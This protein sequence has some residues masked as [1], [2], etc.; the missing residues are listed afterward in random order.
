MGFELGESERTLLDEG[1]GRGEMGEILND[2]DGGDGDNEAGPP[3][4]AKYFSVCPGHQNACVRHPPSTPPQT[5]G[6]ISSISSQ[7]RVLARSLAL[8]LYLVYRLYTYAVP[9]CSS[10]APCSRQHAV[11]YRSAHSRQR[12]VASALQMPVC[13]RKNWGYE[14]DAKVQRLGGT[15]SA[16][17]REMRDE[18]R[19]TP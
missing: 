18:R 2:K 9:R 11:Q 15:E 17:R 7:A 1:G 3:L 8:A 13:Q 6:R 10:S 5:R 19:E 4:T 14:S 16:T 12:I